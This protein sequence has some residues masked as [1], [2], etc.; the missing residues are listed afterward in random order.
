MAET[1]TRVGAL[2]DRAAVAER[3]AA[4]SRPIVRRSPPDA[5][6]DLRT[7]DGGG[8][9]AGVDVDFWAVDRV[10]GDIDRRAFV[11]YVAL[12]I[13]RQRG[14]RVDVGVPGAADLRVGALARQLDGCRAFTVDGLGVLTM[15]D[16]A[17]RPTA[18]DDGAG[19]WAI[20]VHPIGHLWLANG[21]GGPFLDAVR[22]ALEH[23]TATP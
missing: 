13:G 19:G 1:G 5:G 18:I 20:V 6:A 10:R 22:D 21:D 15:S 4:R 7:R 17:M 16:V 12:G 9:I 11:A 14:H 2:I 23:W 3:L 8:G